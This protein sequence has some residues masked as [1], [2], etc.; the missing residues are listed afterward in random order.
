MAEENVSDGRLLSLTGTL[1]EV[2]LQGEIQANELREKQQTLSELQDTLSD[3]KSSCEAVDF[4]LKKSN[5]QLSGVLCEIEQIKRHNS[6]LESRLHEINSEN[7]KL[8]L[9]I[10]EQVE[11]QQSTLARY[12]AYRNKM[13]DHRMA[14]AEAESQMP[15]YKELMEARQQVQQLREKRD[16]LAI[17]LQNPEGEAVKQA[18][19]EIDDLER[20]VSVK[21]KMV[22]DKQAFLRK[23]REVQAQ[24][25]K[26]I[27]IQH[28]RYDAIVKRLRCQLSKA[29][30][31][32]RHLI[33]DIRRM[34]K[35]VEELTRQVEESEG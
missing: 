27:E 30:S 14:V 9:Q 25:R 7:M 1:E 16:A 28:K 13:E 21:S 29:Q 31:N 12:S 4:E 19:Q 10:Q 11:R 3:L 5:S 23:E 24:L 33:N 2:S 6:G 15:I 34:E 26:D 35:E 22:E 20:Q 18:Q 17:D 32:H 8:R